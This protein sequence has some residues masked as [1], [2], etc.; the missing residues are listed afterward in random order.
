MLQTQSAG[1]LCNIVAVFRDLRLLQIHSQ[2]N[3]NVRLRIEIAARI[4][5][6]QIGVMNAP[7]NRTARM[8]DAVQNFFCLISGTRILASI[9]CFIIP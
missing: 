8:I 9:L 2:Q 1:H 5:A 6:V 4:G 3:I 7:E